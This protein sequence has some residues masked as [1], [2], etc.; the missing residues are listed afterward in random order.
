MLPLAIYATP[1]PNNSSTEESAA[2]ESASRTPLRYMMHANE[3]TNVTNNSSS[4]DEVVSSENHGNDLPS[5]LPTR[6]MSCTLSIT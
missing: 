2:E 4:P 1:S 5:K 6:D 3:A